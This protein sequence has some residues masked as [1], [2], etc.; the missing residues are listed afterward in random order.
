MFASAYVGRKRLFSN[1]FTCG[2]TEE[3]VPL[4]LDVPSLF[5]TLL[6]RT[7]ETMELRSFQPCYLIAPC[8][9]LGMCRV[10]STLFTG[11]RS[12]LF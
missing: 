11:S 8:P 7:T 6:I 4:A 12:A 5:R 1:A 9:W 2:R 3:H 10:S